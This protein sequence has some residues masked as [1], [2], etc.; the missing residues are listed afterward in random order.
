MS[1]RVDEILKEL[2][3]HG[4]GDYVPPPQPDRK[5]RP[6]GKCGKVMY[7][8]ESAAK[9]GAR[10]LLRNKRSNTSALRTYLCPVCHAWHMSSSYYEDPKGFR[11]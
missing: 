7:T 5:E 11:K 2:G 8:S 9:Q 6:R 10:S 1:G 3:L 4:R